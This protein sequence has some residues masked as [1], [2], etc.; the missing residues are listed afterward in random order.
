MSPHR[1]GLLRDHGD[2]RDRLGT[3]RTM[4]ELADAGHTV[5]PDKHDGTG[6][7]AGARHL[8]APS[9]G[10]I[11]AARL[12][13]HRASAAERLVS[14]VAPGEPE[15]GVAGDMQDGPSQPLRCVP[16][17][18]SRSVTDQPSAPC[19]YSVIR[20]RQQPHARISHHPSTR[21]VAPVLLRPNSPIQIRRSSRPKPPVT[22]LSESH[23]GDS[24]MEVSCA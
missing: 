2:R 22:A 15:A 21:R 8:W 12:T 5:Q 20:A 7:I 9:L 11:I 16:P 1:T 18:A 23:D 3:G 4:R 14:T 13:P 24:P 10:A 17:F 19:L 6:T